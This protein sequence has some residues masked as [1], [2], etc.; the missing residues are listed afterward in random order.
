MIWKKVAKMALKYWKKVVILHR[1]QW[2]KVAKNHYNK[3]INKYL[4]AQ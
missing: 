3:L 2:K 1:K 4:L